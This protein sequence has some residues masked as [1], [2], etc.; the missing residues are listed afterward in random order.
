L[1]R[2]PACSGHFSSAPRIHGWIGAIDSNASTG[3]DTSNLETSMNNVLK[4]FAVVGALAITA[5]TAHAQSSPMQ[6][7]L[8]LQPTLPQS[9]GP[10]LTGPSAGDQLQMQLN[11]DQLQTAER[12]LQNSAGAINPST[13]TQ[14]LANQERF[15]GLSGS[16]NI[17]HGR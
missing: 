17:L 16:N 7:S 9:T 3:D 6:P 1:R 10:S 5:T 12:R 15:N 11:R 4:A 14:G 2:Q 13:R 8:P